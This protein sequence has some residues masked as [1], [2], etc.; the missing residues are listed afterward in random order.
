MAEKTLITN[1]FNLHNA[2]QFR[3]SISETANSIYYVFAGRSSPYASGD[4]SIPT[5]LNSNFNVNV[6]PYKQI[7][8]GKKLSNT[9]V[10]VMVPRY[11]WVSNTIYT[12]Y[13][14]SVNLDN[15][16]FY[17]VVNAVSSYYVFK[18]LD[19]NNDS[20]STI[21]PDF[22]ETGADDDFYSTSDGYVWKYMY[23]IDKATFEKFATDNFIPVVPN[24]NVSGNA[25]SGSIDVIV[26]DFNGSNYNTFLTNTFIS[27]DISVGGN[28][29]LYNIANNAS[30][31]N[32][33][34][35]GSYIYITNGTGIGQIR[36]ILDYNVS[37]LTKTLTL[38]S[39]FVT[40]P[41]VSSVYEITPSVNIVGNG[42]GA[43]ARALVNTSS[44]NTISKIEIIEK[45]SG[46]SYATATVVGN[47]GG[48]SNA[49]S[50]S[51][52]LG[53][54][55]GHGKDA[56]I[57]LGGKYLGISV[58]FAN[59]ESGT[60]PT[61][62]DYRTIGLIKDP[63]F[64]NV[65]LT[66]ASYTGI[67]ADNETVIQANSNATGV[68]VDTSTS[69]VTVS[70]VTGIFV[71]DQLITGQTSGASANVVSYLINGETK[72]FNTFDNRYKYSFTPVSGTFLEDEKVYQLDVYT[73]NAVFHSNTA[74]YLYLTNKQ[75]TINTANTITGV[76]SS[77]VATLNTS[78][79]PDIVEGSGEVL[80][81]ENI[82]PTDRDENQSETIKIILKF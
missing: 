42:T 74:S 9:D 37:G 61:F 17:A 6:D 47:T 69:S 35:N 28:N 41:D 55:G 49:A 10:K 14:S 25:V 34:Y 16:N 80:Y 72:N 79:P 39:S 73:A 22:N 58:T 50:L 29:V 76:N 71:T 63:Y 59:N 8:F 62:N 19:N 81:I 18:V 48:I 38:E 11:D 77:A 43:K 12:Q 23:T 45:G 26:V 24:A 66:I 27:T 51:V 57:E 33:F 21:K 40:T 4:D 46:Y 32:D 65:V 2:K 56:E 52:V 67:F 78:W 68:I 36:K 82:D 53:P 15:S 30:S 75:G 70:N 5:I 20:P 3:E 44:S 1:Y 7:V 31:D 60:I 64:S 54:K 13:D